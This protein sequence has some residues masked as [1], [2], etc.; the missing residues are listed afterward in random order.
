MRFERVSFSAFRKDV[1]KYGWR[2]EHIQSAYDNIKLPE[3]KTKY[4]AGYDIST[5]IGFPIKPHEKIIIPTGIKAVFEPG[6]E[7]KY[8]HLALYIR[9]S[10]G[11]NNQVIM[12]NQTGIIDSDYANNPDNDGDMLI[13]LYSMNEHVVRFRAGERILQGIFMSHGV[14]SNDNAVGIRIGGVGSTGI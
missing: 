13:A 2:E 1:L 3:R 5:P 4:S 10:I 7:S 14:A 11:I 12:A 8:W 9:S 6:T